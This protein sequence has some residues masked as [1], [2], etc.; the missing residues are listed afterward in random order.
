MIVVYD[1]QLRFH[2]IIN[3]LLLPGSLECLSHWELNFNTTAIVVQDGTIIVPS[4]GH[5]YLY[6]RMEFNAHV[7]STEVKVDVIS[8]D[9]R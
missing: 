2:Q 8:H 6:R 1:E 5:Y 3:V 9:V 7:N 4:T